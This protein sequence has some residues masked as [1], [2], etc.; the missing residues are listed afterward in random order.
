MCDSSLRKIVAS[1]NDGFTEQVLCVVGFRENNFSMRVFLLVKR[2]WRAK[3]A[4]IQDSIDRTNKYAYTYFLALVTRYD[5]FREK[6]I[7]K[8][9]SKSPLS[10]LMVKIADAG[11]AAFPL[12][13]ASHGKQT[14]C[15]MKHNCA[16]R[17]IHSSDCVPSHLQQHRNQNIVHRDHEQPRK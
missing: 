4:R 8:D 7:P 1:E 16:T 12:H 10:R 14:E 2:V 3:L 9:L 5:V 17:G 13:F 6:R 11:D 15:F